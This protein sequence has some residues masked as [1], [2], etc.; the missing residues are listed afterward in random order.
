MGE[1]DTMKNEMAYLGKKQIKHL[2]IK[3]SCW[4]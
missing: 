4:T 2:L 3:N 1:W